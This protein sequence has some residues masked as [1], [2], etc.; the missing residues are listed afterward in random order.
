MALP[1]NSVQRSIFFL[2][3]SQ[4]ITSAGRCRDN[5]D[6]KLPPRV[7]T[8]KHKRSTGGQHLRFGAVNLVL[9][10]VKGREGGRKS[11]KISLQDLSPRR[12][13]TRVP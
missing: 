6:S 12:I 8:E 1:R 13:T 3:S 5:R 7:I 9:I 11:R 4:S 10:G 2:S